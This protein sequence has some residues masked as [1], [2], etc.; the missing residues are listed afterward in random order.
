MITKR[1]ALVSNSLIRMFNR[2]FLGIIVL[3]GEFLTEMKSIL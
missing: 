2:Y 3:P 1:P